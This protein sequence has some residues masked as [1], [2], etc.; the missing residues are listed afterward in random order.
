LSI[1][2]SFEHANKMRDELE[3]RLEEAIS[4][5]TKLEANLTD[6]NKLNLNLNELQLAEK[7]SSLPSLLVPGGE[8]GVD[9]QM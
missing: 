4:E 6:M 9:F 8:V 2:E 7:V 1:A 3:R 5:K